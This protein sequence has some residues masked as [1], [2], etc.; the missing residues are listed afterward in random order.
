[1]CRQGFGTRYVTMSRQGVSDELLMP[2]DVWRYDDSYLM[3]GDMGCI[4]ISIDEA[5][6]LHFTNSCY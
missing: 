5:G 4:Y 2:E 6:D 1:M 3:L